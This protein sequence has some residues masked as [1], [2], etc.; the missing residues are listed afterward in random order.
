MKELLRVPQAANEVVSH[1][2]GEVDFLRPG[3]KYRLPSS[4]EGSTCESTY[5]AQDDR[6]P[7]F[8]RHDH[9][10]RLLVPAFSRR[11]D[12][13]SPSNFFRRFFKILLPLG[14]FVRVIQEFLPHTEH[15]LLANAPTQ[16]Q[17]L[18]KA[19]VSVATCRHKDC[20]DDLDQVGIPG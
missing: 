11:F 4:L 8:D 13:V 1:S 19:L 16:R 20:F 5:C 7:V 10:E 15:N 3:Y 12:A 6:Y 17:G 9:L 18:S 2:V 14:C